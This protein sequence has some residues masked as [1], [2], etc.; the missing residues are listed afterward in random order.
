MSAEKNSEFN[1]IDAMKLIAEAFSKIN[2]DEKTRVLKWAVDKY[3]PTSAA[4]QQEPA[5]S[6]AT[7]RTD[8]LPVAPSGDFPDLATLFHAANPNTG[9][10]KALVVAY[11]FQVI[12]NQQDLDSQ[13]LNT[14]LK[15]LGHGVLNITRCLDLLISTQPQLVIQTRKSGTTKQA[16]KKYRLTAAGI[17][18]VKQ[19]LSAPKQEEQV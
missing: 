9:N 3:R 1:E 16:R 11:W 17:N 19:M 18:R 10:E 7:P 13:Q 4:K 5:I 15:Q 2:D 6:L 8:G 12:N 14:E